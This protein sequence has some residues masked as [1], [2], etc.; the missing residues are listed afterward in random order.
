MITNHFSSGYGI[1]ENSSLSKDE[2]LAMYIKDYED[3]CLAAE[4]KNIKILL[5]AELRFSENFNDYLLYGADY[6]AL[7]IAYDY[8]KKGLKSYYK[9][10]KPQNSL[11]LQAHPFRSGMTRVNHDESTI[12]RTAQN[13]IEYMN[14]KLAARYDKPIFV[15]SHLPLHYSM[16]TKKDGDGQYVN[17]IFDVL[18]KAGEKGLNIFFLFGHDHSNG[19][20]DYLGGARVYLKKGDTIQIAQSSKDN[21]KREKLQFT[22]MNAGYVGYYTRVNTNAD[23]TLTMTSFDITANGV[24]INRYSQSGIC[25]LKAVGV[26]N[27]YQGETGYDPECGDSSVREV[28]LNKWEKSFASLV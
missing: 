16:R 4:N 5:G 24:K 26:T 9:K 2:K 25:G 15:V 23:D 20:D 3:A 6:D 11:L 19:W 7:S 13:L 18:N 21:F 12:K 22:Y 28:E 27:T 10:G 8:L 17:Y 1:F 14:G